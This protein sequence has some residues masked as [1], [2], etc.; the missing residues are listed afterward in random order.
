MY[1]KY[2][3]LTVRIYRNMRS[4]R[5]RHRKKRGQRMANRKNKIDPRRVNDSRNGTWDYNRALHHLAGGR[6]AC[7]PDGMIR[8]ECNGIGYFESAVYSS[9]QL[10][11][12]PN[13]KDDRRRSQSCYQRRR[14]GRCPQHRCSSSCR[15]ARLT[16]QRGGVLR[17]HYI[18]CYRPSRRIGSNCAIARG[19]NY[20]Q[21]RRCAGCHSSV[22]EE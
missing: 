14:C 10:L 2:N 20:C 1:T 17:R 8:H 5:H 12:Q 9:F 4:A 19:A 15:V 3:G 11:R 7:H 16:C 13:Y 22:R 18:E 21:S 6:G